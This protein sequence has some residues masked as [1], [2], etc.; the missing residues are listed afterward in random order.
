MSGD[1]DMQRYMHGL[2]SRE[3]RH[4]SASQLASLATELETGEGQSAAPTATEEQVKEAT[5]KLHEAVDG[6]VRGGLSMDDVMR[7]LFLLGLVQKRTGLTPQQM[8][9]LTLKI[10]EL[11]DDHDRARSTT[12]PSTP[13]REAL[14]TCTAELPIVHC[15]VSS[16][17]S[18]NK[19]VL[20]KVD[21]IFL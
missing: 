2:V 17:S 9:P 4:Y 19:H 5:E 18:L 10:A 14:W 12:W 1:G 20:R 21:I 3:Q 13:S 16:V 15:D 11:W 6:A 7:T 8:G